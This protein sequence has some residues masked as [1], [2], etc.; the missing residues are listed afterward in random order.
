MD[1]NEQ[2]ILDNLDDMESDAFNLEEVLQNVMPNHTPSWKIRKCEK[3]EETE[4]PSRNY[5]GLQNE[6]AHKPNH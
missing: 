4:N 6:Y 1:I 2:D 5:G 3:R